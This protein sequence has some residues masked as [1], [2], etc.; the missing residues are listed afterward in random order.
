M[1]DDDGRYPCD[2]FQFGGDGS[3]TVT[4]PGKPGY[5]ISIVSQGVADGFADYGNGNI[6]LPGPFF[7]STEKTACWV[8]D[9]TGFSICVF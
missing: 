8:S 3:F 7:R 9:A 6:S 4:A 2:F 5:T 1:N